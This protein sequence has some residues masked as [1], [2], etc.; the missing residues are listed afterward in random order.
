MALG[1]LGVALKILGVAPKVNE[2]GVALKVG[3]KAA[4]HISPLCMP[5]HRELNSINEY[6]LLKNAKINFF[7]N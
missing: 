1:N 6:S 5:L 3:E 2:K 4:S 7:I